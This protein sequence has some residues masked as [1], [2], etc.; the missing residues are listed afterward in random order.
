VS[1]LESEVSGYETQWQE[2]K[3]AKDAA[4]NE[5][6]TKI[7]EVVSGKKTNGLKDGFWDRVGDV[8]SKI[9]DVVKMVC[10][11]AGILAIFLAWVPV[12]GQVLLVLAAIGAL[13][14]IV[15]GIVKMCKEGFSWGAAFAVFLGV[16][17]LFGGRAISALAKYTKA[18]SVV[19][20]TGTM[21]NRAARLR[22]GR[23]LIRDSHA[24]L[25]QSRTARAFDLLKSPF[26]RSADDVARMQAFRNGAGF[27]SQLGD[28]AR[29]AFPNPFNDV[30][31]RA[32]FGNSD[33][34]DSFALKGAG[35]MAGETK[36]IFEGGYEGRDQRRPR[37]CRHPP[38]T[39]V[40]GRGPEG[41]DQLLGGQR[42]RRHR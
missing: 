18:K 23:A 17:S 37:R 33:V 24:V 27:G 4:A 40:R 7:A 1:A 38:G 20:A 31:R 10:D 5:A 30:G 15:E 34:I 11:I 14:A 21:T 19:N 29:A 2:G 12:L 25:Q 22:F 39:E 3:D 36:Y 35:T 26:V 42:P 32:L 13:I 6:I 28:A 16:A 8:W 41:M 9:G